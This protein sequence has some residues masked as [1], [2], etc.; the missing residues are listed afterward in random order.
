[1]VGR[2]PLTRNIHPDCI[3]RSGQALADASYPWPACAYHLVPPG[4]RCHDEPITVCKKPRPLIVN[5]AFGPLTPFSGPLTPFFLQ[6][7][8]L[9]YFQTPGP[10]PKAKLG[11]GD[12]KR[13]GRW[14]NPF[15]QSS[16]N[17]PNC[18]NGFLNYL[19]FLFASSI[20]SSRQTSETFLR[21]ADPI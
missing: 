20:R 4:L 14:P 5:L 1:M 18:L 10:I 16:Q 19:S 3:S 6:I 21:D 15:H 9:A 2:R 8:I 17:T 12:G 13:I 11:R 7:K